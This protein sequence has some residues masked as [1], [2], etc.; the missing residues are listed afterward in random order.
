M[1]I[2]GALCCA[3]LLLFASLQPVIADQS[4]STQDLFG[5]SHAG[6]PAGPPDQDK[7]FTHSLS[8]GNLPLEF[9][10]WQAD[11]PRTMKP[12]DRIWQEASHWAI[13]Q[14]EIQ[15]RRV[16]AMGRGIDRTLSGETYSVQDNDS[17][18]RIGFSNR[19]DKG[20]EMGLE[21]EVRFR[22]E[23]PTV[24]EKFK[25]IVESDPDDLASLSE[26]QR[27]ETLRESERTDSSTTGALRFLYP[28][29][30]RWDLSAD[31]GARLRAPPE[32]L[33]RTRARSD[34]AVSPQWNLRLDQRFFYFNTSGWG[35]RSW[36]G[37]SRSVMDWNFLSSSEAQWIH[38]DR[39]FEV[40]Q[41]LSLQRT[42]SN[43]HYWRYRLGVLGES[44]PNWQSTDYF[45]DV[46]YRNRLY[47]DWLYAEVI[48]ALSFPRENSF[49]A[50][51]SIT[52]RIEMFFSGKGDL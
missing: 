31:I 17:Y 6:D 26:Q 9:L 51:P 23:L 13:R 32:L 16:A 45:A 39:N 47:D 11:E 48:P 20:G 40:A 29:A 18:L 2:R 7:E 49:K 5:V 14:Q 21:P 35:S 33:W 30:E 3:S 41:V 27:Q 12:T 50:N 1:N 19:Y 10:L 44:E 34:W 43:R 46:L 24:E 52:L 42:L 25:L 28:V 8:P 4:H 36:A 15:S 38:K 22:L 37:F